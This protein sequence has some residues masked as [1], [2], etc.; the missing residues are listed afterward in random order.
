MKKKLI[1]YLS[2][3]I[4][5]IAAAIIFVIVLTNKKDNIYDIYIDGYGSLYEDNVRLD[6][7]KHEVKKYDK[8]DYARDRYEIKFDVESGEDFY[9]KYIKT[10]ESYIEDLDFKI[11]RSISYGYMIKEDRIFHYEV[12]DETIILNTFHGNIESYMI[13][14][15]HLQSEIIIPGNYSSLIEKIDL[16]ISEL[17]KYYLTTRKSWDRI[18]YED[19][20][21]VYS[22]ISKD[23]CKIEDNIV[24]LKGIYYDY[25]NNKYITDDYYVKLSEYEG[26]GILSLV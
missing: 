8:Y 16:P 1:I 20:L 21:K 17:D 6:F 4:V 22:Y 7:G 23:I 18:P 14:E 19:I 25:D 15:V 2:I 5:A 10:H 24:Y 26:T 9:N 13:G 11:A 12:Y 3:L